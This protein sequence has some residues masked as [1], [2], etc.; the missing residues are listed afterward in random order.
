MIR[1]GINSCDLDGRQREFAAAVLDPDSPI[2]AGITGPDGRPSVKRFAVYRNNCVAGLVASLKAAYPATCR[3][4][5]HDFFAAMA[6]IYVAREP[7]RSPVMLDYGASFPAFIGAFEPA[8]E[9]PYLRDVARLERAWLEAYHAA[10]A[11]PIDATAL[12]GV[13]PERLPRVRLLLHPSARVVSSTFPVVALWQMNVADATP[14]ALHLDRGGE[15][16]LIFRPEAEVEVRT[17]PPGAAEF[18][19][20][21]LVESPVAAAA[22]L[23]FASA[24]AFDLAATLTALLAVGAVVRHREF[25]A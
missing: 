14:S 23:A 12:H 7:P 13:D 4:V 3:I 5:G 21:L 17:L 18:I 11:R 2:P 6:R 16:A 10:E 20:A 19:Q 24:P 25:H 8:A 15:D 1:R 9:V 22:G